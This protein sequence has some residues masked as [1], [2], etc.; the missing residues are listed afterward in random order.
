M[1]RLYRD[2]DDGELYDLHGD[3]DQYHNLWVSR[4]HADI[5]ASLMHQFIQVNMKREGRGLARR[6][7]A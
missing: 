7:F 5:K 4:Q 6:S 2:F 1:R 3:P